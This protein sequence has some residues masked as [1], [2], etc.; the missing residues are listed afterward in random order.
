[1]AILGLV[2]PYI[3]VTGLYFV[4]GKDLILFFTEIRQNLFGES[5]GPVLS[6]LT[7]VAIIYSGLILI[8]GIAF[9]LKGMNSKKIKARK[10]FIILLWGFFISIIIYLALPSVSYEMVW[11]TAMP[12]SYILAHY[13]VFAKRKFLPEIIF[14]G[15]FLIILL[16]QVFHI[17]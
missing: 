10:T 6:R 11:I 13:F 7:I 16:V 9:L 8:S 2:T 3:V 5:A 4:L 1:V 17:F 14:S 15:L 12:A